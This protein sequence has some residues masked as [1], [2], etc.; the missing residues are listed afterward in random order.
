MRALPD[1][2]ED[3]G[4]W[5]FLYDDCMAPYRLLQR[6]GKA[7]DEGE[8]RRR[9]GCIEGYIL[10]F[11]KSGVHRMAGGSAN[12]GEVRQEGRAEEVGEQKVEGVLVRLDPMQRQQLDHA[13][14][15]P[16]HYER[17][18]FTVL[19]TFSGDYPQHKAFHPRDI[20]PPADLHKYE[21]LFHK[22][23][24]DGGGSIDVDEAKQLLGS[25]WLN[26]MH[27]M[28]KSEEGEMEVTMDEW[29]MFQVDSAMARG[30]NLVKE[31]T[32]TAS[33]TV[34][35]EVYVANPQL[36]RNG[37]P[38]PLQ[39]YLETILDGAKGFLTPEYPLQIVA[40]ADLHQGL[41]PTDVIAV[42][43]MDTAD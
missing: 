15:V 20:L 23:D 16:E 35:A 13:Y 4:C 9:W 1:E 11:N 32:E 34:E 28:G 22:A 10:R 12:I 14:S 18:R 5:I 19:T 3:G 24:Q 31:R 36:V 43:S 29:L 37:L 8:F 30:Q 26:F 33:Y 40:A 21:H 38:P 42:K 2:E 25:E 7:E 17:R 27:A 6:I 39:V 41:Q